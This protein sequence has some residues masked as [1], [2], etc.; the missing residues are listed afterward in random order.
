MLSTLFAADWF[1]SSLNQFLSIK[2]FEILNFVNHEISDIYKK[3][4]LSRYISYYINANTNLSKYTKR[5]QFS[6][7]F[8]Q[9]IDALSGLVNLETLKFL[10]CLNLPNNVLYMFLSILYYL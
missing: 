3:V 10:S 4:S 1:L 2:D 5:I 8:N 6:Y 9:P 7:H